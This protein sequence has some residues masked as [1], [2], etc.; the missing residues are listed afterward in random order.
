MRRGVDVPWAQGARRRQYQKAS[1]ALTAWLHPHSTGHPRQCAKQRGARGCEGNRSAVGHARG[2]GC[3]ASQRTYQSKKCCVEGLHKRRG[4]SVGSRGDWRR[5]A[6][7]TRRSHRTTPT[8]NAHVPSVG[9]GGG[10]GAAFFSTA[11]SPFFLSLLSGL[12]A[13]LPA[14]L[15]FSVIRRM[16]AAQSNCRAAVHLAK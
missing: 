16:L 14:D 12:A 9:V 4:W 2:S 1:S 10:G 13:A 6:T 15:S 3:H 11:F 8:F 7:I 5:V